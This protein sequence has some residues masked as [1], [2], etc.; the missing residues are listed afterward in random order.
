MTRAAPSLPAAERPAGDHSV[1]RLELAEW[2]ER[3]GLL[4]GITSRAGDFDLGLF[5]PA[6]AAAV[7]DRWLALLQALNPAFQSCAIS[8]QVHGSTIRSHP[9]PGPGLHVVDGADGQVTRAA[10]LALALTVADC[11]PVYVAHPGTGTIA[12]LHAGWRGTAQGVLEAGIRELTR[13]AG[14]AASELIMHCGVAI[15]GACYEVGPEVVERVTGRRVT[16]P[17]HLDLRASLT[18]RAGTLGIR[19]VTVSPWCSAHDRDLFFSHRR[20]GGADGRMGAYLG[21]PLAR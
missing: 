8:R 1:P 16:R 12:L 20:S 2:R 6:P 15:C 4:A 17:E 3:Y 10:G 14:C 5:T 7:L 9:D 13:V 19:T 18:V 11:V 21:R